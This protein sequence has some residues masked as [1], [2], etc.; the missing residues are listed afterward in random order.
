MRAIELPLL[1]LDGL[2]LLGLAWGR[3][4]RW[5]RYLPAVA[6][7][8]T[9]AHL[10][11]AGFYPLKVPL[12]L[13]G[14]LLALVTRGQLPVRRPGR[15]RR[16][17]VVAGS[18]LG[19]IALA[20]ATAVTASIP[21]YAGLGWS[22]GFAE[23]H[24]EVRRS[25]AFG[26][27]KGI[28]WDALYAEVAPQIAD[29]EDAGDRQAYAR[30]LRAYAFAL[31]D[32]HV[33]LIGA[34]HGARAAAIGGSYGFALIELDDGRHIAN[35]V[36][37]DGPAARAGVRWGAEI[38]SWGDRP[39]AVA[40]AEVPTLWAD[41]PPATVEGRRVAQQR[42]L[43]RAPVSTQVN[44]T[45]RNPGGYLFVYPRGQSLDAHGRIQID[46]DCGLRGGVTPDIRV[47][48]TEQSVRAMYTEG[49][50][51]ALELAVASVP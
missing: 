29:A 36:V 46:S 4:P 14:G 49:R 27:W 31:P 41:I 16:L 45:F 38:L 3:A 18:G 33:G 21:N 12:Y 32:G 39:I 2:T 7:A 13:A 1:A 9:L 26:A 8:L 44:M 37:P 22:A 28:D 11:I 23:L 25:Y 20:L 42:L 17:G 51:L 34:D 47:P 15:L 10:L 43:T 24:A 48:L 50:D 40:L 35:V 5:L 30:A 6:G 19:L